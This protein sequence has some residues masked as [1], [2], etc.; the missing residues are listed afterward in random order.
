MFK[1]IWSCV[2]LAGLGLGQG[3]A[4]DFAPITPEEK[5][6]TTV[7]GF[8]NSPA[9]VLFRRG[10]F[11]MLD[12]ARGD[13]S[14]T[15]V[16]ETRIKILSEKGKEDWG[17]VEIYH[18]RSLRLKDFK[19]RTVLPDGRVLPVDDKSTFERQASKSLRLTATTI[20]FPGLEVGAIL[21]YRYELKWDSWLYLEPWVFQDEI[22]V[23]S[24]EI[25]YHIPKEMS[26]VGW[27]RD[28]MQVGLKVTDTR[29]ALGVDVQVTANDLPPL[30]SEPYSYPAIDL[31]ARFMMVPT[32]YAGTEPLLD[33]WAHTCELIEEY[34]YAPARRNNTATR[35]RA[36]ELAGAATAPLDKARAIYEFVRDDIATIHIPGVT[37]DP[38]AG[39][40]SVLAAKRGDYADKAILLHT[41]LD[42]LKLDADL[43]WA[44]SRS[45]G[46]VDSTLP[47][48]AWFDR[49]LVRL[50]VDGKAHFLDP[51]SRGLAMGRLSPDHE[52]TQAILFHP[53][54]PEVITLPSTPYENNQRQAT[55]TLAL[56]ADGKLAG[57][58]TVTMTGHRAAE[59]ISDSL[60]EGREKD[61]K[62][63]LTERFKG[64]EV[65][66]LMIVEAVTEGKV[67]VSF[68]VS[69]PDEE[70]LGDEASY[71]VARPV[72]P[73]RQPLP[74]PPEQRRTPLLFDYGG[75]DTLELTLTWPEGWQLAGK[76]DDKNLDD[77]VGGFTATTQVD[78]AT[79]TLTYSRRFD[80]KAASF[81]SRE[82]YAQVRAL[83]GEVAK[84]DAQVVV[85][86]RK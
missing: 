19:G 47:T 70:V 66:D 67:S 8:P 81:P 60:S 26:V 58:G 72:G 40:D 45:D 44:A 83:Y 15:L 9:V 35:R 17:E 30:V 36:K 31:A 13:Q 71:H 64:F 62:D 25:T 86:V 32:K 49:L 73:V 33:T 51:S 59:R 41:L 14:S 54:K 24:S 75:R 50:T 63:W 27:N 37:V 61:W 46:I 84:H 65:K 82:Q 1:T 28:P 16:V 68:A 12:L 7:A 38:T 6:L 48:L 23:K 34:N 79:R 76:P 69:Q 43:V 11:R 5:A 77:A 22:P 57:T 56:D 21:D 39:P 3:A 53:R 42:S 78:F 74:T 52:G 10:D 4:A 80:T 29:S 20:T 55:L 85:L 18:S 2:L